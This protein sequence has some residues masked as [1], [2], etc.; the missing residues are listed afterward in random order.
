M[1][2]G[3]PF[4]PLGGEDIRVEVFSE[5]QSLMLKKSDLTTDRLSREFKVVS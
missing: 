5:T 4:D 3:D 1:A 2:T